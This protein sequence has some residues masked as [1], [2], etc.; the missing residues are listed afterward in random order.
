MIRLNIKIDVILNYDAVKLFLSCSSLANV[1]KWKPNKGT[2]RMGGRN[3]TAF[4]KDTMKMENGKRK[5]RHKTIFFSQPYESFFKRN[6]KRLR[7]LRTK[8]FNLNECNKSKRNK[9]VL[10]QKIHIGN[11]NTRGLYFIFYSEYW[12]IL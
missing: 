9:H 10:I 3:T 12:S 11:N 4:D 6:F 8:K 7:S 1:Q 2:M 5:T